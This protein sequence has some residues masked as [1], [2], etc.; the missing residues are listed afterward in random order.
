MGSYKENKVMTWKQDLKN[1]RDF[2]EQIPLNIFIN[3]YKEI[4]CVEQDLP[5]EIL[6][7]SSIFKNYWEEKHFYKFEEWFE[8]FW[9]EINTDTNKFT[10]L[11]N[12][13]ET[14]FSFKYAT[15]PEKEEWFKKG[16]E[17][18]MH[19]TWTAVLTQIDFYYMFKYVCEK[20]NLSVNLECNA[21]L[22][23][24]GIDARINNSIDLQIAKISYRK[25]ARIMGEG[26][27]VIIPYPVWDFQDLETKIKNP[28]TR[29][30]QM[31]QKMLES[32]KKYFV[33]LNNG[34]VVF[35]E[36]YLLKIISNINDVNTL[37]ITVKNLISEFF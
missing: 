10:I 18:R 22:D 5:Y 14:F 20:N 26:K 3:K 2:L 31:Y 1:F 30:K 27:K 28:Q 21:I 25:E 17:A 33:L 4:K 36:E 19:R 8:I 35:S 7:L 16:F 23:S 15:S 24:K 37:K 34:F 11:K 6:P 32:F 9:K 13:K 29:K 12:F